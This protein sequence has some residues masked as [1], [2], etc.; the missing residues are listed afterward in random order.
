MCRWPSLVS[1]EIPSATSAE[2][3]PLGPS[4]RTVL[5]STLYLTPEGSGMGFFPIRDIAS[6]LCWLASRDGFEGLRSTA[7]GRTVI[8]EQIVVADS[9]CL[10]RG[11]LSTVHRALTTA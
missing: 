9:A 1:S 7:A 5:P 4:T 3:L 2:T 10:R 8:G 11:S 6:I